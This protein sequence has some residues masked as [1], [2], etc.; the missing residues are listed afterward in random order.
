MN[1]ANLDLYGRLESML[2][3]EKEIF[4]LYNAFLDEIK[5]KGGKNILD[6]GCG[7]GK[8]AKLLS[9]NGYSVKAIDLS[10]VMIEEAKKNHPN[11][12]VQD[13]CDVKE[14]YQVITAV[15]DVLNYLDIKSLTRFLSC[16][17]NALEEDGYFIADI[18]SLHGFEDVAQGSLVLEKGDSHGS[19][20]SEFDGER[21]ISDLRL[22]E[23]EGGFYRG[24]KERIVQYYHDEEFFANLKDLELL[25]YKKIAL[26]SDEGDKELLVFKK[27]LN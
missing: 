22:F 25:E 15:F 5:E 8:F 6:V 10:P 17:A 3:F 12:Y 11:S 16:V 26:F 9:D 24:Y 7:S 14:K 1:A 20:V 2:P 18:N 23:K 19:I 13:I 27:T 21:L 4:G